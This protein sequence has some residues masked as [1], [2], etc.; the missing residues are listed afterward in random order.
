MSIPPP[1]G[2]PE[3]RPFAR[4]GK[5]YYAELKA[6]LREIGAD[7]RRDFAQTK[8]RSGSVTV[9]DVCALALKYRLNLKAT[10]D[11]LEAER[12]LAFGTYD[13]LKDR[14]LRPMTMLR[15]AW[16]EEQVDTNPARAFDV[17]KETRP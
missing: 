11:F 10:F 6:I 1:D 4:Q 15:E 2:F 12:L 8:R 7:L 5:A 3:L 17:L 9:R 16:E 13:T 14:G